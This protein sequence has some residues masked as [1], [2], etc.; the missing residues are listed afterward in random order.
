MR[1]FWESL[2]IRDK[3]LDML[4]ALQ[5]RWEDSWLF[6]AVRFEHDGG[7]IEQV[8]LI[9]LF[10]WKFQAWAESRWCRTSFGCRGLIGSLF[11][12]LEALVG[13]ILRDDKQSHYYINGF[14]RLSP[15]IKKM[16]CIVSATCEISDGP[17]HLMLEDDRL[18]KHLGKVDAEQATHA[19][20]AWTLADHVVSILA[21][22]CECSVSELRTDIAQAVLVQLAYA[23]ARLRVARGLPWCLAQGD[24]ADNLEKF[25]SEP[26]PVH[27]EVSQRIHD[28][29]HTG[30]PVSELVQPVKLLEETSWT[31]KCVEDPHSAGSKLVKEHPLCSRRSIM[32]RSF[33]KQVLPLFRESGLVMKVR[34]LEQRLK[35][36]YKKNPNKI[37]ARHGVE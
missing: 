15:Q 8:T 35:V 4:V 14:T 33:L 7:I 24:M 13:F 37:G 10:L 2:G 29:M 26:R 17:M 25:R 18:V 31:T 6:V 11:C 22:L 12:G 5:L 3:W 30:F 32:A 1:E 27:C 23:R 9:L 21:T 19:R 34:T 20:L 36:L 28:L 16:A